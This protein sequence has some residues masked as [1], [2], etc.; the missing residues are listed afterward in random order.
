MCTSAHCWRFSPEYLRFQR[1]I[2]SDGRTPQVVKCDCSSG[3]GLCCPPERQSNIIPLFSFINLHL[4]FFASKKKELPLSC[5]YRC[6]R[7]HVKLATTFVP[8]MI[9]HDGAPE[10]VIHDQ[11]PLTTALKDMRA[12]KGAKTNNDIRI[13]LLLTDSL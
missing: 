7:S 1:C 4:L 8:A 10:G 5:C 6:P 3:S 12:G 11:I 2:W 13:N 9:A